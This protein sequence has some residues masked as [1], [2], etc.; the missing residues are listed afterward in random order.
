MISKTVSSYSRNSQLSNFWHLAKLFYPMEPS[1][2]ARPQSSNCMLILGRFKGKYYCSF[3][4]GKSTFI[5][6]QMLDN[7]FREVQKLGVPIQ[8]VNVVT[9]KGALLTS[10]NYF[11]N[12]EFENTTHLFLFFVS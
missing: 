11:L 6:S 8:I 1:N 12:F 9:E 10:D 7:I 5:Y 3:L 4:S 2:R